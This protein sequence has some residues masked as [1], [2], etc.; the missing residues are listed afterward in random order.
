MPD[1]KYGCQ[2]NIP[3]YPAF[4]KHGSLRYQQDIVLRLVQACLYVTNK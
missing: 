2:R 4:L 1:K 3:D